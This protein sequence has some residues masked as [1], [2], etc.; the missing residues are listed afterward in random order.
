MDNGDV[1]DIPGGD[2]EVD[3]MRRDAEMLNVRRRARALPGTATRS[4]WRGSGDGELR[5]SSSALVLYEKSKMK[6]QGGAPGG[7]EEDRREE[8]GQGSL[9]RS[10]ST[11]DTCRCADLR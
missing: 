4:G 11:G 3:E 7:E 1:V 10:E 8:R 5:V 6:S 2:E 9:T